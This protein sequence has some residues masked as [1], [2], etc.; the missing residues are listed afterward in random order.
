MTGDE[1]WFV[2]LYPSDHMFAS[3]RE[4]VIPRQKQTIAS[5]KIM[6]TI[7]FSGTSLIS[8]NALPHGQTYTKEYFIDNILSD[9]VNE[10]RRIWRQNQ[11][12]QFFVHMDN[13]MCHNQKMITQEISDAKF[14]RLPH[15]AYSPDLSP[16]DF[17]LF[18]VLKQ[19]VKDRAFQ[20]VE[21][22]LEAVTLLWN[23]VRFEQLQSV[24][25]N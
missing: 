9:L 1:S 13:S 2:C 16:C 6:L 17:W 15:P 5:R 22:I 12:G 7:F 21:E 18:E 23:E 25:L 20:R 24:F 3:W 10:K 4:N 19:K 11:V 14:E 8:L